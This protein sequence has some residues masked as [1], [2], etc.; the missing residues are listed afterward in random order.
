MHV[1]EGQRRYKTEACTFKTPFQ[2]ILAQILLRY[3]LSY[4]TFLLISLTVEGH[5]KTNGSKT[6][7]Y[8]VSEHPCGVV[9]IC[10][11]SAKRETPLY[12][13][14]HT[15]KKWTCR[16]CI[17]YK[18]LFLVRQHCFSEF[19]LWLLKRLERSLFNKI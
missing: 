19:S 3:I 18:E 16:G 2:R 7:R 1:K 17:E 11:E 14:M 5:S 12:Y 15:H 10:T 6:F 13:K 8:P 9:G 4:L